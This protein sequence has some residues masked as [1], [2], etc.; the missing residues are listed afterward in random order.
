MQDL[1]WKMTMLI[2][3]FNYWYAV[4]IVA[5]W[6]WFI[7]WYRKPGQKYVSGY[8]IMAFDLFHVFSLVWA[9]V[10]QLNW[11]CPLLIVISLIAA[12]FITSFP[13]NKV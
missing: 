3:V 4:P 1:N 10:F 13:R 6:I 7:Q 5:G 12:V 11:Y 9:I 8:W 2:T